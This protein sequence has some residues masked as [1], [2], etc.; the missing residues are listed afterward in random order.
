MTVS[1][2]FVRAL[3]VIFL[4][5]D[6][7][8][9]FRASHGAHGCT[10]NLVQTP[11]RRKM[12]DVR[13]Q[14]LTAPLGRCSPST[15]NSHARL[16]SPFATPTHA[17][18]WTFPTPDLMRL[19]HTMTRAMCSSRRAEYPPWSSAEYIAANGAAV[20]NVASCSAPP[21]CALHSTILNLWN[22]QNA[23]QQPERSQ[24]VW[25]HSG[26]V[27]GVEGAPGRTARIARHPEHQR[28]ESK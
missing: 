1:T 17:P 16:T 6:S 10:S 20:A 13:T 21:S 8:L 18:I 19:M 9:L 22:S 4:K 27:K 25:T 12:G 24:R 11:L 23:Q 15:A 26:G 3:A 5:L 14:G 2:P 7:A 28:G